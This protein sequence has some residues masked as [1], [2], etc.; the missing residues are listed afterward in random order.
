MVNILDYIKDMSGENYEKYSLEFDDVYPQIVFK[1]LRDKFNMIE[2]FSGESEVN[3]W[4]TEYNNKIFNISVNY[5]Q[6]MLYYIEDDKQNYD[7][8]DKNNVGIQYWYSYYTESLT[9]RVLGAYDLLMHVI[10]VKYQFNK[11]PGS[12][13]NF[14]VMKSLKE[15]NLELYD[16]LKQ[17]IDDVEYFQISELRNDFTHNNNPTNLT[18]GVER[19]EGIITIS[20]GVRTSNNVILKSIKE[21]L[22]HLE[23]TKL[24]IEKALFATK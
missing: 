6:M 13:F 10:N 1:N 16:E 2:M 8:F 14:E 22:S 15:E 3:H 17:A 7:D 20:K 11:A 4:M 21:G 18:S 5:V 19:K 23:R 24:A 12:R 9:Q